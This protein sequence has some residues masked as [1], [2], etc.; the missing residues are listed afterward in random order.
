MGWEDWKSPSLN[1]YETVSSKHVRLAQNEASQISS[2]DGG[3][4]DTVDGCEEEESLSSR[5]C[6]TVGYL[7]SSAW[8][9]TH[10]HSTTI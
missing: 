10:T 4:A 3:G 9:H 5:I 2:A 1:F 6:P 7:F 8:P